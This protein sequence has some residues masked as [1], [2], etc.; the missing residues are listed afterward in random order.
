VLV[1]LAPKG[2]GATNAI[3]NGKFYWRAMGHMNT[4]SKRGVSS[5][6]EV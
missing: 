3:K 2:T 4:P 5:S 1:E 6:P